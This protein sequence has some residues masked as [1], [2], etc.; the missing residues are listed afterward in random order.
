MEEDKGWSEYGRLVLKELERLN[1]NYESLR[2]DFD[3]KFKEI[4]DRMTSVQNTEKTVD[5]IKAWQEKVNDVWSPTQMKEAKDEVY[6]Q[7][8]R[9]TATV[10]ILMFIQILIG[11]IIALKNQIFH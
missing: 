3:D 11:I 1:N 9:W 8:G 2:K 5:E 4:N 7:K 10:A 6:K